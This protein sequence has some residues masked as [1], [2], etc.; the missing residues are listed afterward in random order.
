M[1]F[2]G[3]EKSRYYDAAILPLPSRST[4]RIQNNVHPYYE[5]KIE[6][7]VFEITAILTILAQ[8]YKR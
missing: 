5:N 7:I 8:K 2:E 3:T 4:N 1:I 6:N